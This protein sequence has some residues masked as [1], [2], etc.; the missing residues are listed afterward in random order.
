MAEAQSLGKIERLEAE[1][2]KAKRKLYLVPLLYSWED[3]P[4]EYI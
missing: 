3:A 2:F 4:P 1:L